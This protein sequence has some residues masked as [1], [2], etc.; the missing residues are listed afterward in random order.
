MKIAHEMDLYFVRIKVTCDYTPGTESQ[1]SGPPEACFEGE[2]DA[3]ED[4]KVFVGD[5]EITD[6]ISDAQIENIEQHVIDNYKLEED[7]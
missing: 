5:V 2:P 6:E 3:I 4:V 1:C 7:L